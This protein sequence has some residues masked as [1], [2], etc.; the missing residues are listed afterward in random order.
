MSHGFL[1]FAEDDVV[2]F[3]TANPIFWEIYRE[4]VVVF[5]SGGYSIAKCYF[6]P[7]CIP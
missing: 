1:G 2:L 5:T 4:Y 3:P 6:F 7:E